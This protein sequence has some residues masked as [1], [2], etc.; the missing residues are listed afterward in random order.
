MPIIMGD[1]QSGKMSNSAPNSKA[2]TSCGV[3]NIL[4]QHYNHYVLTLYQTHSWVRTGWNTMSWHLT[5]HSSFPGWYSMCSWWWQYLLIPQSTRSESSGDLM[6]LRSQICAKKNTQLC[7][8]CFL[9][10][11]IKF[12]ITVGV[13]IH[14]LP[15]STVEP[16]QALLIVLLTL[17]KW[18]S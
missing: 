9:P 12:N 2:M 13:F 8:I 3:Y 18:P 17:Y 7:N 16:Y 4:Y 1:R 14:L 11:I 6:F 10:L 5:V 15:S